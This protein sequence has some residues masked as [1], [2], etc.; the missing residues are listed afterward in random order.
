MARVPSYGVPQVEA[1]NLPN[2]RISDAPAADIRRAGQAMAQGIGDL[3]QVANKFAAE[4]QE[5]V[6]TTRLMQAEQQINAIDAELLN[7]EKG[8]FSQTLGNAL[9]LPNRVLPE[10]D[11][12]ASTVTDSLP[13]HLKEKFGL[14]V[15]RRRGDNEK[16]LVRHSVEQGQKYRSATVDATEAS[17][18]EDA[19]RN[20]QN[21]ERVSE[22]LVRAAMARD[23]YL[24]EIGAP[25]ETR[26]LARRGIYSKGQKAIIERMAIADPLGASERLDNVGELMLAD[27]LADLE[28]KLNPVLQDVSAEDA[29]T[30]AADGGPA[31]A[32]FQAPSGPLPKQR[33]KP[34]QDVANA[35]EAAAVKHGVPAALLYALAEQESG[36]NPKAYNGEYGA[37]GILQFIPGTARKHGIDPY[38]V[39]AA[40]DAAAKDAAERIRAGGIEEAIASHFAGPGGGN[41][42]PKTRQYVREVKGRM[43]RWMGQDGQAQA[44]PPAATEAEALERLK[45]HPLAGDPRWLKRAEAHVAR[46]FQKRKQAEG[47]AERTLLEAIYTRVEDG[48][49]S[50]SPVKLLA[51]VPGAMAFL[52]RKGMVD[53]I[54]DRLKQRR[55]GDVVA[56]DNPAVVGPYLQMLKE[57][58]GAFAQMDVHRNAGQMTRETYKELLKLQQ[59]VRDGKHKPQDYAS[60]N[61]QLTQYVYRPLK[62]EG[63][64]SEAK[65]AEFESA[66]F[67]AKREH[68][69]RTGQQPDAVEREQIM[70]RLVTSFA[71]HNAKT[72]GDFTP[73]Y[74]KAGLPTTV[75]EADRAQILDAY[76]RRGLPPPDEKQIRALYLRN[77]G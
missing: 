63:K 8:A 68:V 45:A 65:R 5:K 6:N 67:N 1:R 57:R 37:A 34:T 14:F 64:G 73:D 69:A 77:Q 48:D 31:L 66:W 33:G 49:P 3:A 53:S 36:F 11:K 50:L 52:K 47:E 13:P 43:A 15:Q 35:I 40:V 58:P 72:G 54:E 61:E 9:D 32:G 46:T 7:S 55:A 24:R 23:E 44:M 51:D 28:G 62:L 12:R 30:A 27:D 42:G 25:A 38:D 29:A 17:Y 76:R 70:K 41:R 59:D 26:D 21:P 16:A 39:N 71:L 74:E 56:Q 75:P 60:E 18:L 20:W 2:V 4:E 22:S 10:W 19:A